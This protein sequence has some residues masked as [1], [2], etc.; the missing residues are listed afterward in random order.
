[1]KNIK[2]VAKATHFLV[3]RK[4]FNSVAWEEMQ[5]RGNPCMD[6]LNLSYADRVEYAETRKNLEI[7]LPSSSRRYKKIY[8]YMR[9]YFSK[10]Y[11]HHNF[12]IKLIA[13]ALMCKDFKDF[14][15]GIV[16]AITLQKILAQSQ[17]QCTP[18]PVSTAP[19]TPTP[20]PAT[21]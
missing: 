21:P 1:M 16:I 10:S 12:V 11:L 9:Q 4:V 2:D 7:V 14:Q 13:R 18:A 15:D 6:W 17:A 5:D 3:I 20:A 19:P 8:E